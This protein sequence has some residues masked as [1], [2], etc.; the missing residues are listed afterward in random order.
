MSRVNGGHQHTQ[1][2]YQ[3]KVVC[4][5]REHAHESACYTVDQRGNPR[6][7]CGE[8]EHGHGAGCF[9]RYTTCGHD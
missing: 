8:T 2:C 4:G 5:Q 9:L 6:L 7:T 1:A 3:Q